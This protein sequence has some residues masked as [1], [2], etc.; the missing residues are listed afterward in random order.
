[1]SFA[2]CEAFVLSYFVLYC[3]VLAYCPVFHL[4]L[5]L[6]GIHSSIRT[7]Q[8]RSE[9]NGA[10]PFPAFVN[11]TGFRTANLTDFSEASL[12]RA[13]IQPALRPE[14][15]DDVVGVR[16][17][18]R[19]KQMERGDRLAWGD[20]N[21]TQIVLQFLH[22]F[23][24]PDLALPRMGSHVDAIPSLPCLCKRGLWGERQGN[25]AAV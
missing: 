22:L 5:F 16:P 20:A 15:I 8:C 4:F 12:V 9:T 13:S 17:G 18:D 10:A 25:S 2:Q 24:N 23:L 21:G 3:T 1:M 11:G 14:Q 7:K 6:Q 19:E